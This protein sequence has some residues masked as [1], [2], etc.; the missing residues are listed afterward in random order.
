MKSSGLC[1]MFKTNLIAGRNVWLQKYPTRNDLAVL[2]RVPGLTGDL[3]RYCWRQVYELSVDV[4]R[5]HSGL[6]ARCNWNKVCYAVVSMRS[7]AQEEDNT[8]EH[9]QCCPVKNSEKYPPLLDSW[10]NYLLLCEHQLTNHVLRMLMN[11]HR[12]DIINYHIQWF[13]AAWPGENPPLFVAYFP[14]N[15]TPKWIRKRYRRT[16]Y[17]LFSQELVRKQIGGDEKLQN[18]ATL[19]IKRLDTY[20]RVK[21]AV[22][23]CLHA[24]ANFYRQ[25]AFL[26]VGKEEVTTENGQKFK[27]K[28]ANAQLRLA[29][30][31]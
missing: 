14:C 22:D 5:S 8:I 25:N 7:S 30:I 23:F 4:S 29:E 10:L 13:I 2:D 24:C 31:V 26:I 27:H 9:A 6:S 17:F 20:Q 1:N 3:R 21:Y 18:T 12:T 11:I 28:F 16:H 19:T 15:S